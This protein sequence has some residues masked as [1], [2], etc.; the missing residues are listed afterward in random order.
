MPGEHYT[1]E[2]TNKEGIKTMVK[3]IDGVSYITTGDMAKKWE[4]P[5]KAV[6]DIIYAS[7]RL[8]EAEQFP[9]P[10]IKNPTRHYW[11]AGRLAT[12]TRW[13]NQHSTIIGREITAAKLAKS[14]AYGKEEETIVDAQKEKEEAVN[15]GTAALKYV[16]TDTDDSMRTIKI[17]VEELKTVTTALGDYRE[18]II[19]EVCTLG[20]NNGSIGADLRKISDL[21]D[22]IDMLD[23]LI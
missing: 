8:P 12:L 18:S 17:D 19:R 13:W 10:D 20:E 1:K 9:A 11:K 6:T 2:Y 23:S 14:A 21:K 22:L 7:K 3:I 5:A 16:T 15:I 4:V